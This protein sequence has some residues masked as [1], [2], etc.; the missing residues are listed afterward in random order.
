MTFSILFFKN[1]NCFLKFSVWLYICN[2]YVQVN[3]GS[4]VGKKQV[5]GP[6]E[7][8]V[9][10]IV[11]NLTWVKGTELQS[12]ERIVSLHHQA[13]SPV[14]RLEPWKEEVS[15]DFC[16]PYFSFNLIFL[17]TVVTKS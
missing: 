11:N 2:E 1:F 12:Y 15:A 14:Q 17:V 16:I 9:W 4:H 8:E 5:L 3:V 7:L 10:D 6:L 13:V